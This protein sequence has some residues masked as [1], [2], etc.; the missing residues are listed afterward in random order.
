MGSVLQLV[1]MVRGIGGVVPSGCLN[2][3]GE[4]HLRS[5]QFYLLTLKEVQSHRKFV[6][7][8]SVKSLTL[9]LRQRREIRSCHG[10]WAASRGRKPS[11]KII[12]CVQ[13][14]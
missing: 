13:I 3:P 11:G 7:V 14:F 4:S 9:P 2:R 12:A 6:E 1:N 8:V 5:V 10:L